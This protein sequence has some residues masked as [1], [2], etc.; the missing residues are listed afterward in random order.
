MGLARL[1]AG[2]V[3]GKIDERARHAHHRDARLAA[4][5]RQR[6]EHPVAPARAIE[7]DGEAVV[8]L[9]VSPEPAQ[10]GPA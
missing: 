6:L 1:A 2:R 3:P 5:L 9:S 7:A 8:P 4:M 10:L